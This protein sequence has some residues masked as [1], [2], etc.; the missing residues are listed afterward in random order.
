M[1]NLDD[2]LKRAFNDLA[3]G[4]PHNDELADT[5]RRRSR[6]R[7]A[8]TIA[9]IAAVL[10]VV[11]GVVLLRPATTDSASRSSSACSPLL[12]A[13]LPTWAHPGFSDPT[14]KMPLRYSRSGEVVAIVFG[15]PLVSPA[16]PDRSNKILWAT[17]GRAPESGDDKLAAAHDLRIAGTLKGGTGGPGQTMETTVPGGPGP[18]IV[19][20][21]SAGCWHLDL[22]WGRHHD[23][24]DLVYARG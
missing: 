17:S 2:L 18:S 20:V 13:V 6:Y 4:A 1:N 14:P 21:P 15:D 8:V 12:T 9:P 3:A 11:A 5:V 23:T 19:D 16:A 22:A 7:R 24:I 10:A